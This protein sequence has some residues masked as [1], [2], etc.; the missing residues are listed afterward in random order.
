LFNAAAGVYLLPYREVP[1]FH[2]LARFATLL[3][4][5]FAIGEASAGELEKHTFT[6]QV[7]GRD[8]SY[9]VYTPAGYAHST[10]AL[11]VLYLLHGARDNELSWVDKGSIAETADRLIASGAIPPALI[12]MPGCTASWWIDGAKEHAETMFWNELEPDV[13]ARYRS[14]NGRSG[15]LIAGLSAGGFG[16]FHYTLKH[17]DRFAAAAILSPAI[18][19]DTPPPQST[20]R[21]LPPF[22]SAEG[23]FELESW[24][25]QNYPALLP[26]YLAQSVRVPIYLVSGLQDEFGIAAETTRVYDILRASQPMLTKMQMVPGGHSWTVWSAV[27][28]DAM[29]YM[30]QFVPRPPSRPLPGVA[31]T[32]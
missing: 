9:V 20:A 24:R 28:A 25:R 32:G 22:L 1:L 18:C 31:A 7:L 15:R 2:R 16:A 30:F 21:V 10:A 19:A 17:P 6:S 14:I 8:L 29:T 12:V 27:I 5:C 3:V 13:R 26:A 23:S 11:P 4:A